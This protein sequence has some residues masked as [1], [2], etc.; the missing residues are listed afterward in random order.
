MAGK[1]L[2]SALGRLDGSDADGVHLLWTAPAASGY[3]IKGFDIQRRDAFEK[4]KISCV[5]LTPPELTSLHQSFRYEKS[6]F[7]FALRQATCPNFPDDVPDQPYEEEKE[8][9]LEFD[10]Q[11]VKLGPNPLNLNSFLFLVFDHSGRLYAQ[12]RFREIAGYTGLDCGVQL[13]IEF[14]RGMDRVELSMAHSSRPAKIIAF[15]ADGK[16]LLSSGMHAG[17]N[18]KE[19]VV[20]EADDIRRVL[21]VAAQNETALFK[22]CFTPS[23]KRCI[24]F[25]DV[26]P[27]NKRM[28]WQSNAFKLRIFDSRNNNLK[29]EIVSWKDFRGLNCG[30]RTD[31]VFVNPVSQVELTL[32]FSSGASIQILDARGR[33]L[34]IKRLSRKQAQS[35]T[36]YLLARGI[37]RVIIQTRRNKLLLQEFCFVQAT[38]TVK[39]FLNAVQPHLLTDIENFTRKPQQEVVNIASLAVLRPQQ[40][41]IAYEIRF[42]QSLRYVRVSIGVP[43]ALAIA[44][45]DGKAVDAQFSSQ[46]QPVQVIYFSDKTIDR[47]VLYVARSANALRVCFRQPLKQDQEDKEWQQ[48]PYIAR[49]I[50][51]PVQ[52]VNSDLQNHNDEITLAKSRILPSETFAGS[53]FD[54]IAKVMNAAAKKPQTLTPMYQSLLTREDKKDP[55]IEV[56]PW[57]YAL[58]MTMNAP[59]RRLLGFGFLDNDDK[60][61]SGQHYD[62]RISGHFYRKDI[63]EDFYGFHTVPLDLSLPPFF[64]LNQIGCQLFHATSISMF[65]HAP[66]DELEFIGRKGIR[67]VPGMGRKSLRLSFSQPVTHLVLEVE[68]DAPFDLE[69][70]AKTTDFFLGL[71][72]D[73]FLGN[74]ERKH[75]AELQFDEPINTL[76]LKGGAFLYGIRLC[77][78]GVPTGDPFDILAGSF[79]VYDVPFHNSPL[80]APPTVLG[81]THLQE[82]IIPGDP[83]ETEQEPPRD[84]GFRLYWL[85]PVPSGGVGPLP[86]PEDIAAYPPFDVLGFHFQR[87]HVDGGGDFEPLS[88]I[89]ADTLFFGNRGRREDREQVYFGVD[90]L[91]IFPEG[92]RPSAEGSVYMEIDDILQSAQNTIADPG[93][94]FQYRVFSVDA[95]GRLSATA[96][97]GSVVR[98]EK[99]IGPPQP[100]QPQLPPPNPITP[101]GVRA[102]LLQQSDP[103]L[104]GSDQSLLGNSTNAVVLQWGWTDQERERDSYAKEFRVYWLNQPPDRIHGQLTGTANLVAGLY[105]MPATMDQA[106]EADELKGQYFHAGDYPFKVAGNTAGLSIQIDFEKS[107]LDPNLI[108]QAAGFVFYP[109][110]DGEE[111]RPNQWQVRSA[112]IPITNSE[113]YEFIFRDQLTID[114]RHAR[115]RIWVGVSSADDQYYIADEIPSS[116]THGG[117]PGNES[118][119]VPVAVEGRY[120]GQ[121]DFSPP[122]PLADVP[123]QVTDEPRAETVSFQL[124][125][126]ALLPSVTVPAGHNILLQ[127]FAVGDLIGMIGV[128]ASDQITVQ[129]PDAT[130]AT[131]TLAN[132]SDHATFVSQIRNAEPG[133]IANKF[134]MDALIRQLSHL[135]R[136]WQKV[137]GVWQ[138]T[139]IT[140][141]VAGKAERYFYRVRIVDPAGHISAQGAIV[142][143]V[144]RV[145]SIRT[146]AAPRFNVDSSQDDHLD[147]EVIARDTF[148]NEWVLIFNLSVAIDQVLDERTLEKAQLLRIPNRRDLYPNHAIRMRLP[149]GQ[150]LQPAAIGDIQAGTHQIPDR[151]VNVDLNPG[152]DK[153]VALWA[154]T[155]TRDGIPSNFAGPQVVFTGPTPLVVPSLTVTTSAGQDCASWPALTGKAMISV[156]R[157]TDGG[158]HWIRVTPWLPSGSTQ[159]NIV[160]VA[161]ERYYRL[162]LKDQRGDKTAGAA[163]GPLT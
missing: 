135:E 146:P 76:T 56:R 131:Y 23:Q 91:R 73:T 86:W 155:M 105:Q 1:F 130:Q 106:V 63:E 51:L 80:P 62:Y 143:K 85:P 120:F 70:E 113:N 96:R 17:K 49:G 43:G 38:S 122:S 40:I 119:I 129:L 46:P 28:P 60:L 45:R 37:K 92:K 15:A 21:I 149:E 110:L 87:S 94:L 4:N 142:P 133:A 84:M 139:T 147:V 32:H 111:Q 88:E 117:R 154:V 123:E 3:S 52:N 35:Q 66:K 127:R 138:F 125:L 2:A 107:V 16:T 102:R 41:C 48:V 160:A 141:S 24:N 36:V 7:V 98:L 11:H 50:Q 159:S 148:D 54:D 34:G 163:F 53:S 152:F 5:E 137:Q 124:N 93:S 42:P 101:S 82:P 8:K 156:E 97:L 95:I 19:V 79:I 161:G 151:I 75:R 59:W 115:V 140:D 14:P 22:I 162:V 128:N 18:E 58:A 134:L 68:A 72:G 81:T 31:I 144:L 39:R 104:S 57:P 55:Y 100:V 108:P 12:T 67:L 74:V 6:S 112:V 78:N 30:F 90:L 9:C 71:S 10:K 158:T 44:L 145:A 109:L 89:D 65:P 153:R 27:E 121:P 118:S 33:R 20:L 29:P 61:V 136:L 26:R 157:S 103:N 126:P 132:A 99:H 47:V 69:Y 114:A 150:L 116:Q 77:K 25:R 13:N 83:G 64:Y